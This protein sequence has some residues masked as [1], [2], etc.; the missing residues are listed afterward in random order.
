MNISKDNISTYNLY[1]KRITPNQQVNS[2]SQIRLETSVLKSGPTHSA[3]WS[4]HFYNA[5]QFWYVPVA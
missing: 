2:Q 3:I 4:K 5:A 1:T